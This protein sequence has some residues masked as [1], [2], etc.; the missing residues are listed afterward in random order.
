MG[1][2]AGASRPKA[3]KASKLKLT[4]KKTHN[5]KDS[6]SGYASGNQTSPKSKNSETDIY[7]EDSEDPPSSQTKSSVLRKA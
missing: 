3:I 5:Q 7:Y 2:K 1:K 6:A 4:Q